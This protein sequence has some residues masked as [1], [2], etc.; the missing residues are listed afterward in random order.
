MAIAGHWEEADGSDEARRDPRRKLRLEAQGALASG[1]AD[2]VL[3]HNISATGLLVESALA[4]APGETLT[5]DLPE[6]GETQAS[7]VW[8]SGSFYGCQFKQPISAGALSAAQL[9]GT[10]DRDIANGPSFEGLASETF[11]ARLQRLRMEQRLTQAQLA[12]RLGVSKP[13]VWAWEQGKARPV[14]S[15]IDSIARAL[16]VSREELLSG[17]GDTQFNELVAMSRERIARAVGTE[18]RQVRIMIEL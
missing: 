16:E 18:P 5:I 14:E 6:A 3:V 9:R 11:G 7:V 10:A 17:S 2:R 1:A 13:T 4:L 8:T 15:R 12:D